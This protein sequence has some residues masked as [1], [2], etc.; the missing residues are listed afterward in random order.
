[1]EDQHGE[2]L[3][4]LEDIKM[5]EV[6]VEFPRNSAT[7]QLYGGKRK[8]KGSTIDSME[9]GKSDFIKV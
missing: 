4:R 6:N 3:H 2:Q 1:M 5:H 9:E 8:G 7:H